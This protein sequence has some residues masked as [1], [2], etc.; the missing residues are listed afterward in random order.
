MKVVGLGHLQIGMNNSDREGSHSQNLLNVD[1]L[2]GNLTRSV[3]EEWAHQVHELTER[4]MKNSTPRLEAM[5]HLP[6]GNI[7]SFSSN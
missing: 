1:Y 7:K 2:E 6:I 5:T 4:E 3:T